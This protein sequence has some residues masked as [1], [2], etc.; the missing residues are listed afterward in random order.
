[1]T[2]PL[3]IKKG[4]GHVRHT[5]ERILWLHVKTLEN[6]FD[7]QFKL[8]TNIVK[9]RGYDSTRNKF[10][11]KATTTNKSLLVIIIVHGSAET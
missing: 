11:L 7:T 2:I 8:S 1:M 5:A 3:H 9:Q 6:S 10:K 4:G